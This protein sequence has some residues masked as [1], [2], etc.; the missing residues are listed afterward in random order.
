[1]E[2]I[3]TA[4]GFLL[5]PTY[6]IALLSV[7]ALSALASTIPGMNAFLVMALAFPFILFEIDEPAIGLVVLATISGVSNTLD[8]IPAILIGQPSGP[9]GARAA[10]T[11]S[12]TRSRRRSS[13][14]SWRTSTTSPSGARASST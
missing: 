1:M 14:R 5:E 13:T 6:W 8:S 4:A 10:T 9:W 2:A 7:V 11:T 3:A 12:S